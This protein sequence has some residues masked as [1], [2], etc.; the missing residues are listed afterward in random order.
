MGARQRRT[1]SDAKTPQTRASAPHDA[2]DVDVLDRQLIHGLQANGRMSNRELARLTGVSEVTVAARIRRLVRDEII[3]VQAVPDPTRLGYPV[4][5]IIGID[6]DVKRV[7]EIASALAGLPEVRYVSITS[8][9]YDIVIAAIVRSN[10]ELLT[11]LSDRVAQIPGIHK[12]VT[13]HALHVLK[14]NPDWTP[15]ADTSMPRPSTKPGGGG[16]LTP[17]SPTPTRRTATRSRNA[18][19][20][21]PNR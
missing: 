19:R 21:A 4:E 14:R 15:F 13:A 1:R 17:P 8:G 16:A 20:A 10:A 9:A 3:R 6:V 2:A 12:L 5:A 18:R 7:R 11:F